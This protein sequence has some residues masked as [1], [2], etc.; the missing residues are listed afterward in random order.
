MMEKSIV[1]YTNGYHP[2]EAY[3]IHP[4]ADE[5]TQESFWLGLPHDDEGNAE[6][7]HRLFSKQ[8]AYNSAF[9]WMFFQGNHW[10]LG[11]EAEARLERTIVDVLTCRHALAL[12]AQDNDLAKRTTRIT[13]RLHGVKTFLKSKVTLPATRFDQERH[14]LNCLTGVIDLRSG[15]IVAH[16]TNYFTYCV[17]V[18]YKPDTNYAPWQ[19]WLSEVVG[20]YEE[21]AEWLQMCVGY[22]ITG[23][24]HEKCFFYLY[25]PFSSGKSTFANT[26]TTMLG[27]PLA[28]SANFSTFTK[29]RDSQNFDLAPLKPCRF[30]A[31]SE[32]NRSQMMNTGLMKQLTGRDKIVCSFKNKDEFRYVP[33]FKLWLMSNHPISADTEDDAFWG[34]TK[35]IAFPH[36][37]TEI[38]DKSLEERMQTQAYREMVLAYAVHGARM[39]FN[40]PKGLVTPDVV[41]QLTQKQREEFDSIHHWLQEMV[42]MSDKTI[43][44]AGTDL[45]A[46]YEHWCDENGFI[47]KKAKSFGEALKHKG[48]A[49]ARQWVDGIQRR[50]YYGV[51]L[52][53]I[54]LMP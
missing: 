25:G 1:E 23:Y 19:M 42:D 46:S 51:K 14:L 39:W 26:I 6:C 47:P 12:K 27:E 7:V 48:F 8:I 44:T 31:A 38:E 16:E 32:S 28:S 20:Q 37:F 5:L 53:R 33:Q 24:I 34:R 52:N 10:L 18:S 30:V 2:V 29:M 9:G 40:E 49:D 3:L 13:A 54:Q 15:R 17:P 4:F 35:V 43:F 50:G 22:S 41:R 21:I 45:R 11:D 36:S